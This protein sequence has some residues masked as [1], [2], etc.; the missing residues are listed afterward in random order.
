MQCLRVQHKV[1]LTIFIFAAAAP[2]LA[3]TASVHGRVLDP[4]G[5]VVPHATI[6]LT[7]SA[8]ATTTET[9]N[10][11]GSFSVATIAPG[12]YNIIASAS[13]LEQEKPLHIS[14]HPGPNSI[15]LQ[16]RI[17]AIRQQTTYKKPGKALAPTRQATPPL[18][19]CRA[20][21]W[22]RSAIVLRI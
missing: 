2:I 21:L 19:C 6:T 10:G 20:K 16:L 11:D 4:S 18:S 22:N 12:E 1:V 17:A 5:A 7:D 14:L 8:G 15:R 13:N 3:Q 9:A